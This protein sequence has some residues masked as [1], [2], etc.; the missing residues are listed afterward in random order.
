MITLYVNF[1]QEELE[2]ALKNIMNRG[3]DGGVIHNK[4]MQSTET[5]NNIKEAKE[6]KALL[7]ENGVK[8]EEFIERLKNNLRKTD[9]EEV[10]TKEFIL[11][12]SQPAITVVEA[13]FNLDYERLTEKMK[14]IET[15]AELEKVLDEL[16]VKCGYGNGCYTIL[17][18]TNTAGH[19]INVDAYTDRLEGAIKEFTDYA[20]KYDV[21]EIISLRQGEG[22]TPDDYDTI[23]KDV[24]EAKER[25]VKIAERLNEGTAETVKEKTIKD[26]GVIYL[27]GG[28]H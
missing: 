6:I 17:F 18:R 12:E 7:K 1:K 3:N 27:N 22:R 16:N 23:V 24:K 14:P 8:E 13:K 2:E 25:L 4:I 5:I 21:N 11:K 9:I 26:C 20:E 10:K 28:F 19:C 15:M